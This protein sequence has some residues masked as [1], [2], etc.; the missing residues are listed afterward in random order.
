MTAYNKAARAE[1]KRR[2]LAPVLSENPSAYE[3][4]KLDKYNEGLG[5]WYSENKQAK[6]IEE[7]EKIIA[8]KQKELEKNL[9]SQKEYDEWYNS[10]VFKTKNGTIQY[11]YELT[12]PSE[13]YLNPKWKA[14]YDINGKPLGPKGELHQFYLKTYFEAQEL[15]PDSQKLGYRL[16][17]ISKEDFE[18]IS[19]NGLIDT[20]SENVKD[21]TQI[22]AQDS[23]QYGVANA[24][25]LPVKFIPVHYTQ[26]NLAP[27]DIS[28]DLGRS[29]LM[30]SAMAN[31]FH[32]LNEVNAEISL[33]KTVI[34][35][36]KVAE[37]SSGGE[38]IINQLANKQNLV[39]FIQKNGETYSQKHVDDFIDMIVY[40]ETQ[41]SEE[42]FGLS[43]SKI[44][45]TASAFS[46]ITS[47]SLDALKG[48]A[49]N[50]QGNIQMII[51]ANSGQF[52]SKADLAAGKSFYWK[53]VPSVLG[54]FGQPTPTSLLGQL[55]EFYDAI[56]GEF[57]DQY[58][59]K[60][61][62]TAALKLMS[63]DT[64]FFNQSFAEHEIQVSGMCALMNATMVTD[65]NTGEVISLLQAHILYGAYGVAENTN[66]SEKKRQNFQN[67]LHAL[68]KRMHGVYNEFDKG[69]AQ[70]YSV[71]RL[72]IMYRK[73]LVPGY[74]RRFNDL[75]MD[76]ELG[77]FT[78]GYYITFWNLF[79]KDLL[80]FKWNM[81][82]GWSTYTPF[83]KAQMKRVIA[84]LATIVTTTALIAILTSMGDDDDELKDNYAY[85]FTMYELVRMKSETSSYISPKDAYRVVRSPSAMTSTL[86]RVIKFTDQFFLT[87]D[88]D[89]LEFK[90]KSGVWDK[91]D[92]K[93]WAYFLK[94]IGYSG[95]NL[96]PEEAVESFQGT[97]KK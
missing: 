28:L 48:M 8:S 60:V 90:R 79:A 87:W 67:K 36:R 2:G 33:F 34:G 31:R 32:A 5:K 26:K 24:S 42:L 50:L 77:T 38:P 20:I 16:P 51:E 23:Q 25:N 6:P 72:A 45:N 92:N 44:T 74:R 18:R 78:E 13:K 7:I 56:Q 59:K 80:T 76:Q 19:S 53:S 73:H 85:N 69:T 68:N 14:L 81:I 52:F 61:T 86:E 9:I 63:L 35:A 62:G 96:K 29:V 15:L 46:A 39:R 83:Q 88:S 17:D 91:G 41:A 94:M 47:L 70:K 11:R 64:I 54:D 71:T 82:E 21:A 4:K 3:Q 37:T 1:K 57:I 22:R 89:D 55:S 10:R 75:A 40:G 58:G 84:E 30:F 65:K 95:Y 49:N 66:F 43:M 93:S 27:E 97:L 12:Q